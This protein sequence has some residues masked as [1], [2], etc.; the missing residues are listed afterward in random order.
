MWLEPIDSEFTM[1]DHFQ[2]IDCYMEIIIRLVSG[3]EGILEG[4]PTPQWMPTCKEFLNLEN[5]FVL[6]NHFMDINLTLLN[7]IVEILGN[8]G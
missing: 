3:I 2:L 5:R 7:K 6:A 8:T 4:N 1:D